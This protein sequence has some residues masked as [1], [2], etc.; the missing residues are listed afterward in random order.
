LHSCVLL[1]CALLCGLIAVLQ[2]SRQLA[3][4]SCERMLCALLFIVLW[5]C[6]PTLRIHSWSLQQSELNTNPRGCIVRDYCSKYPTTDPGD[7]D[8]NEENVVRPQKHKWADKED[9]TRSW[10][11]DANRKSSAV[12]LTYRTCGTC[13]TSGPVCYKKCSRCDLEEYQAVQ[14]NNYILDS[15]TIAKKLGK[16]HKIAKTSHKQNW[17]RTCGAHFN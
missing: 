15:Q 14:C 6:R 11:L 3:I 4:H 13:W 7:Q 1:C 17:L 16:H 12:F 8:I 10:R 5:L 2:L 9:I